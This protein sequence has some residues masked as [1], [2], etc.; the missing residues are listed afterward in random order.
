M[1]AEVSSCRCIHTRG[2]QRQ[3]WSR[4]CC[5]PRSL[6]AWR[7]EAARAARTAQQSTS[8]RQPAR[9]SAPGDAPRPLR[10]P[11]SRATDTN[12]LRLHQTN[13]QSGGSHLSIPLQAT[14]T[15]GATA[16]A[17]AVAAS[18]PPP[19]PPK[20]PTTTTMTV[21]LSPDGG[22]TPSAES[23]SSTSASA[24]WPGGAPARS[25]RRAIAT[26][27]GGGR[28][29]KRGGEARACLERQAGAGSNTRDK[30]GSSLEHNKNARA[31]ARPRRRPTGRRTPAAKTR[32]RRQPHCRRH[33]RQPHCRRPRCR[34]R[35][36]H[37]RRGAARGATPR[38][39]ARPPAGRAAAPCP[40]TCLTRAVVLCWQ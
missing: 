17:E 9:P 14:S 35:R 33:C 40:C 11:L 5:G 39:P 22:V 30:A 26:A 21:T 34:R 2:R 24:A 8:R 15:S 16:A 23:A 32:R 6:A 36:R 20:P 18:S 25:R 19:P 37:C 12:N 31:P 29:G 7:I 10:A 28:R 13:K 4:K 38:A 27:F 1:F 3:K